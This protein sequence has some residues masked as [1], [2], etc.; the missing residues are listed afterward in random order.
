MRKFILYFFILFLYN[1]GYAQ[2]AMIDSLKTALNYAKSDTAK[3]RI[4]IS[5][6]EACNKNDKLLYA[7]PAL[8]LVDKLLA[9]ETNKQKRNELIEQEKSLLNSVGE[10]Y[11]GKNTADWNKAMTYFQRRLQAVEKTRDLK[12]IAT[13]LYLFVEIK[14][15]IEILLL[16]SSL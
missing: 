15:A 11:R 6:N 13:F 4:Y 2:N 1:L 7:E 9:K 12:R 3:L 8:L 16:Y 10:Y 5:M 14:S